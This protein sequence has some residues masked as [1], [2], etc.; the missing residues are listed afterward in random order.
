MEH[1]TNAKLYNIHIL[2]LLLYGSECWTV[3]KADD[4]QINAADQWCLRRILDVC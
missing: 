3:T 2:P 4:R 1:L